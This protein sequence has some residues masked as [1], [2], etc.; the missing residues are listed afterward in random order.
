MKMA[1]EAAAKIKSGTILNFASLERLPCKTSKMPASL[2]ECA[3]L[4][5]TCIHLLRLPSLSMF[6]SF[7]GS[8]S[9]N[10][11]QVCTPLLLEQVVWM[12]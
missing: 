2:I 10:L 4:T 12:T 1:S 7:K 3:F 8:P 5:I 9:A 6:Q 11:N